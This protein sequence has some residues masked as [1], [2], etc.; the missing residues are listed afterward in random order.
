MSYTD[1][2]RRIVLLACCVGRFVTPLLSTMMN[3]SL[4]NIGEEFGVGSHDLGYV[5]SAFLLASVVCMLPI[6]RLGDIAGKRK[7]YLIGMGVIAA[8]VVAIST[9]AF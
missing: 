6:A 9:P 2:E 5:N 3:L 7:V 8:S 1:R 4:L